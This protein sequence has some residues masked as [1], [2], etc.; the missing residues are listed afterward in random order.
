[1]PRI[2]TAAEQG[3]KFQNLFGPL[4][5][6]H[7]VTGHWTAGPIDRNLSQAKMLVRAYHRAHA[8]KGWGGIGYH[9]CVTR[10][11]VILCLRPLTL[12]GAHVG[13]FNTGNVGVMF[14]GGMPGSRPTMTTP[15]GLAWHY[16]LRYAHTTRFPAAH[17]ADRP[18]FRPHTQRRGHNDWAGH[19][20]N[21][22]PG[23]YKR[24][25]LHGGNL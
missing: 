20:T 2:I 25:I 5:P 14:H 22:C 6:E 7:F 10:G 1:M 8:A 18:L 11:G 19:F 16:L 3:L 23:S 15:Q 17:R 21:A 13:G 4:G 9:F 24:E 12:K